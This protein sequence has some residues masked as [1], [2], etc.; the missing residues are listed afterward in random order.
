MW[1]RS[2]RVVM[3]HLTEANYVIAFAVVV[4]LTLA[5]F[6]VPIAQ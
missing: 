6:V 1:W 3:T 4:C 5:Y 2:C